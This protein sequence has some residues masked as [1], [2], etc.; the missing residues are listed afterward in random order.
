MVDD[1]CNYSGFHNVKTFLRRKIYTY[2]EHMLYFFRELTRKP[3]IAGRYNNEVEQVNYIVNKWKE[4]GLDSIE[5][6]TYNVLLS[7]PKQD[8]PNYIAI[9]S[10]DGTESDK[11]QLQE[12][13]INPEQNDPD[14][15]DPFNAYSPSGEPEVSY[16][17]TFIV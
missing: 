11:S 4:Y 10:E 17:F 5:T 6:K 16:L 15:V 14:V 13:V 12:K 9:I 1:V 2:V 7:Y 8:D 3:H